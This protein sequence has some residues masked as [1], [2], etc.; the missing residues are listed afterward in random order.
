MKETLET[1]NNDVL[2]KIKHG[3]IRSMIRRLDNGKEDY[4]D[5]VN[6]LENYL[7]PQ[8]KDEISPFNLSYSRG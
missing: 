4:D 8:L 1:E 3:R 6:T 7:F 5:L 2:E